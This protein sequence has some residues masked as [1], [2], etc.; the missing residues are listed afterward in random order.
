ME[1]PG[2]PAL[3]QNAETVP[4]L[5]ARVP[6]ESVIIHLFQM[7]FAILIL[8]ELPGFTR[9]RFAVPLD[10]SDPVSP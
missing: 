8:L 2:R 1:S 6:P 7:I 3:R 10:S 9:G 5:R 4:G